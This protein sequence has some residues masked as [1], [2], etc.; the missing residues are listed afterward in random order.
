M[1]SLSM[2]NSNPSRRINV[3]SKREKMLKTSYQMDIQMMS[4]Q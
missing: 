4:Q 3:G 1:N 2:S